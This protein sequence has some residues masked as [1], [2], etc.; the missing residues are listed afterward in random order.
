[1][2]TRPPK[3]A[4]PITLRHGRLTLRPPNKYRQFR[5]IIMFY[6]AGFIPHTFRSHSRN[7]ATRWFNVAAKMLSRS[8]R[9]IECLAHFVSKTR[10]A[11][12]HSRKW[13]LISHSPARDA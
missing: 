8:R 11:L 5:H 1:M 12:V 9:A 3:H 7:S 6:E 13:T 10:L 2:M 4:D